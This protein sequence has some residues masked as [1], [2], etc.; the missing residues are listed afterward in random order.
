MKM[1]DTN[2]HNPDHN[3]QEEYRRGENEPTTRSERS[4]RKN[5]K[6]KW[7]GLDSIHF[8]KN[9]KMFF[10]SLSPI[11]LSAHI[12][13]HRDELVF[14]ILKALHD[15]SSIQKNLDRDESYH[16]NSEGHISLLRR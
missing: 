6:K 16:D 4:Q 15:S 5:H 7:R 3:D 10:L 2:T 8:F 13:L 12:F 1:I 11:I 14:E 9:H